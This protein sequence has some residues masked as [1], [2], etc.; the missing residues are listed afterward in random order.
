MAHKRGGSER[1]AM[2]FDAALTHH[3]RGEL[4]QADALYRQV[5]ALKGDHFDALHYLGV[6]RH[7]VGQNDIAVELMGKALAVK[8]R[9]PECHFNIA[10][11]FGALGKWEETIAHNRRA[12]ALRPDYP[13][14]YLNL[15]NAL[16]AQGKAADAAGSYRRAL[17]SQPDNHIL[18]CNLANVLAEL[19]RAD[20]AIAHYR[21]ALT[22][23]PD[24]A[25]AYN[26]LGTVLMARGEI[27][28]AKALHRRA[29]TINPE[30][31][32][33]HVNLGNAC[34]AEGRLGEAIGWYRKAL[35]VR[36][37]HAEA[38]NNLGAAHAAGEQW[39]EAAAAY[40]RAVEL[41][42]HSAI[43]HRNLAAA[44][45]SLG[46]M[47]PAVRAVAQ[48]YA[49]EPSADAKALFVACCKDER[50][51]AH[52]G[53]YRAELTA[54]IAEPWGNPR[55]LVSAGISALLAT[56]AI[57]ACVARA[58]LA[59][60]DMLTADA[61]Y[62]A[63]RSAV[64]EDPLLRAVLEAVQVNHVAFEQ[65]LTNARAALLADAMRPSEAVEDDRLTFACALARQC[66]INEYVF[67]CSAEDVA[68][69]GQLREDLAGSLAADRAIA[70]LKL[71]A[72]AAYQ[73]LAELPHADALARR[74]FSPPV[75]ALLDQQVREPQR[76]VELRASIPRLTDIDDAV[77]LRVR[78]QY[79]Q[80]P[81]P[82]WSGSAPLGAPQ[83]FDAWL[84][85]R[86]PLAPI[87]K[88]GTRGIDYL[89]AGCGTGQ[90]VA[91][92]TQSISGIRLLAIDL[93]LASLAYA[94]R[95]TEARGA[96]IAFGQADILK[97]G[98]T[99][100]TFDVIDSIGV[101]HHLADPYAG[102]RVL[103]SLL[104]PDGL[105]RVG[106]YST[107]AHGDIAVAQAMIAERG[108]G[109][110]A[111]DIRRARQAIIAL[112]DGAA[113]RNVVQLMDFFSL[114][115]CRDALFHVQEH[116]MQL[117]EIAR[118]L[119]DNDLTFIGFEIGEDVRARYAARF[120]DDPARTNLDC[121]HHFEQENPRTFAGMYVFWLQRRR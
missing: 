20:D 30:L 23:K 37:S 32:E 11:A 14:A 26:N 33:A 77:S 41:S 82:R 12:I 65:F 99:G 25:E 39:G 62:G 18:H 43:A 57:G 85:R 78:E 44:L 3:Q 27:E 54:A 103:L 89:I 42:P 60:P 47:A 92:V 31:A 70:P 13:M 29:L 105:M 24:Y 109:R 112:D 79:E 75:A 38:Y 45:L 91:T 9:S 113:A 34:K 95:M 114:S 66:F 90:Q 67:A 115:E 101:L 58:A 87:R 46:D 40:R 104:R 81:Y 74:G 28:E 61:L 55:D 73:P 111:D 22:L 97:L 116:R 36:P 107:L 4:Q 21:R 15:G 76:E 19:D 48:A 93:S 83:A 17:A 49:L 106:L 119:A 71:A 50:C 59:W 7:Q 94:K 121:W 56:P 35:A 2:L 110:S 8:E 98:M 120:P 52:V 118:F 84:G 80:S 96:D 88:L 108:F 69:V 117:P 64:A 1:D 53:A 72:L 68:R 51:W 5:L 86:F 63:D 100:K 16:K 10:L 6:L 102:W